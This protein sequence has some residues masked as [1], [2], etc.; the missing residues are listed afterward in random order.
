MGVPSSAL[1]GVFRNVA[2]RRSDPEESESLPKST[3][4]GAS[5]GAPESEEELSPGV[6]TA[7]APAKVGWSSSA[8]NRSGGGMDYLS[9]QAGEAVA[10]EPDCALT[11]LTVKGGAYDAASEQ[12]YT[13]PRP[14]C[15]PF[16]DDLGLKIGHQGSKLS[17]LWPA[18]QI[19]NMCP[20]ERP[21]M[22]PKRN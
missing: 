1:A 4:V 16:G 15:Q 9:L 13:T 11:L 22:R 6:R 12:K 20:M 21:K 3:M 5:E 14:L 10:E 8:R 19:V 17:M 2:A 7:A 18:L